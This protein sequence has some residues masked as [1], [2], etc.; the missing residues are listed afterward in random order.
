MR[1]KLLPLFMAVAVVVALASE[2]PVAA[3]AN[4]PN[5]KP[6]TAAKQKGRKPKSNKARKLTIQECKDRLLTLATDPLPLYEGEPEKL[7]NEG[8]TWDGTGGE[9]RP[10]CD[11]LPTTDHASR[12]AAFTAAKCWREKN[13]QCVQAELGKISTTP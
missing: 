8:L 3:F 10:K 9:G 6:A 4:Q 1:S 12:L 7:I 13:T 11:L 5:V 2:F